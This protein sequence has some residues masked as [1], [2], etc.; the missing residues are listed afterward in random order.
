MKYIKE[1][2]LHERKVKDRSL[3]IKGDGS[4]EITPTNGTVLING[5]L[6][7]TG[8]ATGPANSLTYYVS[9]EGNDANDGLGSSSDRAKRTIKSAVEAA[10]VGATIQLAPGD[11]YENNPI[12]LKERQ[13]VRGDSLR[14]TQIWPLNNQDDIFFVDNAC[15]IFQ[16][17]FRGLRDPGWCVRIKP[18]A[19]VTTSPYV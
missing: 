12:T 4:I 2:N 8:N 14:N 17:T 15:Y 3:I 11:Y 10:P 7:V 1:Q 5:D 6:R 9:L 18:G 13:T 16:V 19:L